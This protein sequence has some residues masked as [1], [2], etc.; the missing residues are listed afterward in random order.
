MKAMMYLY[1]EPAKGTLST[2]KQGAPQKRWLE[3]K[4][5]IFSVGCYY[6]FLQHALLIWDRFP[7]RPEVPPCFNI[8]E[9]ERVGLRVVLRASRCEAGEITSEI[10]SLR[11]VL[12]PRSPPLGRSGGR[13]LTEGS[14][15]QHKCIHSSLNCQE[16]KW[17][18]G[19]FLLHLPQL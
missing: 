7:K 14:T 10:W 18:F 16:Q 2:G 4:W 9:S 3:M 5:N 13:A 11:C 12:P 19:S 17:A 6:V 15:D 1:L 8:P